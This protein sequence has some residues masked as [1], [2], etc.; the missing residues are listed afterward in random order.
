M[1]HIARQPDI[2]LCIC[3]S[4]SP[5]S[6]EHVLSQLQNVYV[7]DSPVVPMLV[8]VV[9]DLPHSDTRDICARLGP[10]LP[11]PLEIV[12]APA[13]QRPGSGAS[14]RDRAAAVALARGANLLAFV[15]DGL[16]TDSLPLHRLTVIGDLVRPSA[17][18]YRVAI[19][20]C[21]CDRPASLLRVLTQIRNIDLGPLAAENAFLVIVDN[22]PDGRAREVCNAVEPH[23]PFPLVFV[24]EQQRGISY[25]RNRAVTEALQRG[26]DFIAFIDDD[27]LPHPDWL[28]HLIE[29]QQE[30][31]AEVVFGL[32]RWPAD[33]QLADWQRELRTLQPPRA[34]ALAYHGLQGGVGTYNVLIARDVIERTREGCIVFRPEFAATGGGDTDFFLRAKAAGATFATAERSLVVR[35]WEPERM[36]YRGLLRRAFRLGLTRST[37]EKLH[38]ARDVYTKNRNKRLLSSAKTVPD[39]LG[40]M[41]TL[42]KGRRQRRLAKALM[43]AAWRCGELYGDCGGRYQY[44]R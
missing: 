38:M 32:W 18:A 36:T 31:G 25:A 15:E 19:C 6:L 21:T 34:G 9:D 28:R 13:E 30:T 35:T 33:L 37:M 14:G 8:V 40:A 24:E 20:V 12:E 29:K 27:D 5:N 17:F 7:C 43:A 22:L 10:T 26:A 23:L 2:A 42:R 44:Y 3:A 41:L 11:F 1:D 39:V 16:V 4:E